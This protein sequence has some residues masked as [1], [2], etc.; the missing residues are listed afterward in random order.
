I[1]V[2]ASLLYERSADKD[3]QVEIEDAENH[4]DANRGKLNVLAREVKN[5]ETKIH[6]SV[7]ALKKCNEPLDEI[8][9]NFHAYLGGYSFKQF[10]DT[11]AFNPE[12][13]FE[14][15]MDNKLNH[16]PETNKELVEGLWRFIHGIQ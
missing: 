13:P 14:E 7:K 2:A 6:E 16:F 3:I 10:L 8:L 15:K 1:V 11:F 5:L 12:R 9:G 4:F